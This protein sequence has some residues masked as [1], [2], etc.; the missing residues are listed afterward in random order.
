MSIC[1]SQDPLNRLI[2]GDKKDLARVVNYGLLSEPRAI[3]RVLIVRRCGVRAGGGDVAAERSRRRHGTDPSLQS[4]EMCS[5]LPT[6]L[7]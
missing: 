2:H 6:A 3:V 5:V 7:C 4:S 1:E